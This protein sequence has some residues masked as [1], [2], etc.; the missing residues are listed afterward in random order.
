M[1]E[2]PVRVVEAE[3][4]RPDDVPFAR[5]TEAADDAVGRPQEL[6]LLHPGA[7][8]RPVLDIEPFRDDPVYGA[9]G[10]PQPAFRGGELRGHGRK[11]NP[12]PLRK[13]LRG[14]A[15]EP[16][17]ALRE[18]KPDE[19][20]PF[21]VDEQVEHEEERGQLLREL[22]DT[23][24]GGMDPLEEVVEGESIPDGHDELAVEHEM[25][26]GQLTHGL[27]DLREIPG[28]RLPRLGLQLDSVA[29]PKAETAEPVPLRLVLPVLPFGNFADE[30]GQHRR[31]GGRDG[32]RHPSLLSS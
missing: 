11:A 10:L 31:K 5:V 13:M 22:P 9:P 30:Q 19:G 27:H 25:L 15:L 24:L 28:Q 7:I 6:D 29:V 21:S 8:S 23:A 12:A 17:A 3:K 16:A 1:I 18:R 32:E 2:A 26:R 4:E 20:L 14:K